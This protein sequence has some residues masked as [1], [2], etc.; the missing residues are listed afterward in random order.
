MAIMMMEGMPTVMIFF[1]IGQS[2]FR[3]F[4]ESSASGFLVRLKNTAR[5][6]ATH[7]PVT[8]ATAA[9]AIPMGAIPMGS[10]PKMKRGSNRIF[11]IAPVPWV[12]N[13]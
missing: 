7:C 13:V 11:R 3:Y 6:A 5:T 2:N 1:I 9:P 10:H 12:N 4:T 8:V